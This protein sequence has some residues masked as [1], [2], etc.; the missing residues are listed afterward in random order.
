MTADR[1]ASSLR[2][3]FLLPTQEVSMNNPPMSE[4]ERRKRLA[5]VYNLLLDLA[6]KKRARE[7]AAQTDSQTPELPS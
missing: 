3:G 1:K 7:K 4:A 2:V 6:A 5:A